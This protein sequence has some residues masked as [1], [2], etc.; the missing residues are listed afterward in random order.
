VH[1]YPQVGNTALHSACEGSQLLAAEI[2]LRRGANIQLLNQVLCFHL[3]VWRCCHFE[4]SFLGGES[5]SGV[6]KEQQE[7]SESSRSAC[8]IAGLLPNI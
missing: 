4:C 7:G 1:Q 2:L 6:G 8:T 3:I 5:S